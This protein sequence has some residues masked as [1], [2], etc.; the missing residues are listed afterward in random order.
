MARL[1]AM[2]P[3]VLVLLYTGCSANA[4]PARAPAGN[5]F[6]DQ[7]AGI[8]LTYPPGWVPRASPDYRLLLVPSSSED[9]PADPSISL[10]VPQLPWHIPGLIPLASVQ[11]GY[12][13][14]LRGR[15]GSPQ[16]VEDRA[17][18]LPNAQARLVRSVWQ[19]RGQERSETALLIVHSDHV[20]ILRAAASEATYAQTRQAFDA[21][22]SSLRWTR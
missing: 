8:S 2:L 15:V 1:L 18:P 7:A 16:T 22:V 21:V 6:T 20:Y 19:S 12:L 10:D 11:N 4:P 3:G 13:E 17:W 5:L 14:H 9:D